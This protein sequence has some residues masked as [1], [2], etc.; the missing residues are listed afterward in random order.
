MVKSKQVGHLV[1]NV[2]D[3]KASTK[4]YPAKFYTDVL[5]LEISVQRPT[6]TFLT[7]REIHHDLVL[8][9]ALSA[10]PPVTLGQS[11]PRLFYW[12]DPPGSTLSQKFY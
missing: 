5:G 10:A 3:V 8:F 11:G 1:L 6:A 12:P 7:C 4:F 9:Q 2:K